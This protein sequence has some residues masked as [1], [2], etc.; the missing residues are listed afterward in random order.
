[1]SNFSYCENFGSVLCFF[2]FFKKNLF[3]LLKK[4]ISY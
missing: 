2:F 4:K 3:I 1:M